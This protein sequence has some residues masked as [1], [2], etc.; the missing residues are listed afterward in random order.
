[1]E[2]KAQFLGLNLLR[3]ESDEKN[4]SVDD[5]SGWRALRGNNRV[6]PCPGL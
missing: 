1:M 4:I 3:G 2:Y 5:G 6:I